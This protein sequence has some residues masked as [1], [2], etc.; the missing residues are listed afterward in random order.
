MDTIFIEDLRIDT[1]IG[2]YDW[3]REIRQVVSL[4]LEMSADIR[5]AAA[6]DRVGDTLD[7]KRVAK[8]LIGY[9][10]GSRFELIEALVE[11]V[12]EIVLYEFGVQRVRV[13]LG[14][15]GAL[16]FS[17]TVGIEIQ[18]EREPIAPRPVY[19]SIGSNVEPERHIVSALNMLE[20]EFGALR[21]STVYRN[22]AVGFEGADFLNLVAGFDSALPVE[23]LV[24]RLNGIEA[25]HGRDGAQAKFAPRTLDLDLLICGET[26]VE[27]GGV[28]LPRADILRYAFVLKPLAEVAPDLVH[29]VEQRPM[30]ELWEQFEGDVQ[31]TPVA[32]SKEV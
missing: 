32:L 25:A 31:L 8:R 21:C 28:K 17:R 4:D 24:R 6:S 29:P 22:P 30:A 18:R 19:L 10:S 1:V 13:R 16:R 11:R 3:E 27:Q 26:A 7:Y 23:A 14:K 2:I 5:A 12:A 9:V 20:I 15:P